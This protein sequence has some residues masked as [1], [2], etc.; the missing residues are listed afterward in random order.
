MLAPGHEESARVRLRPALL[1]SLAGGVVLLGVW[2]AAYGLNVS[3]FPP[4]DLADLF[5]RHAPGDFATWG[6][7]TFGRSAQRLLLAT[8]VV[9]WFLS[10]GIAGVALRRFPTPRGGLAVFVAALPVAMLTSYAAGTWPAGLRAGIALMLLG[11]GLALAG[12]LA[13]DWLQRHTEIVQANASADA[14]A[15]DWLAAAGS[16]DRRALLQRVFTTALGI[17]AAGL[18]INWLGRRSGAA[19]VV[20]GAGIPI[21]EARAAVA[22]AT[23]V[24]ML[25]EPVAAGSFPDSFAVPPDVR[26][27]FTSNSDFYVV[28]IS[29]RDPAIRESGWALQVHGLVEQP[30]V[31][32]WNDLLSMP[33]IELFGTLMCISY[34]HGSDLISTTRWTGVPL[35]DILQRSGVGA[36]VVDV[37]LY[38]ANG[39]SDSIPLAKALQADTLLAYG[40][41][42]QALPRRHGFP[43]RVYVPGIYGEKN[44]KW[45]RS[46]ELVDYDYSGYWQERGWTDLAVINTISTIDAPRREAFLDSTGVVPVGGITFAGDRGISQV[47]LRVDDGAW[48]PV[49]LE[50]YDPALVWQRWRFDWRPEP[51]SYDLT[52]RAIDGTGTP[53]VESERQPHPDGLTGLFSTTIQVI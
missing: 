48:Q 30:V 5:I 6:I 38:G 21:A 20:T 43:C 8:G 37:V 26:A 18:A 40:M 13:G 22:T 4:F 28:D 7:E 46:I 15:A 44:V 50:P 2:T 47:E 1:A 11:S 19:D 33:A 51:G 45:L 16:I 9:V 27:R 42:G 25:P 53:Q 49:E 10:A 17:G 35:R 12:W 24:A 14:N 32:G 52:V 36:G 31:L 29:T 3:P 39:Y 23:G 41:N 34:T